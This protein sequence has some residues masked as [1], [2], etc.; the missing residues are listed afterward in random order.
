METAKTGMT[1]PW[2]QPG[3]F[4]SAPAIFLWACAQL[5]A[6]ML[7]NL[8]HAGT[9]PDSLTHVGDT[10]FVVGWT[11]S[12]VLLWHGRRRVVPQVT[13][14]ASPGAAVDTV[15]GGT[16]AHGLAALRRNVAR[17]LERLR[18]PIPLH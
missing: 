5:P 3:V 9:S 12:G 6:D 14:T 11:A 1:H 4:A 2:W 18:H 16:D 7:G 17:R 8:F 10:L 13:E 15:P